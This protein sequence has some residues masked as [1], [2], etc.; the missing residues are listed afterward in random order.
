MVPIAPS[1]TR[2]RWARRG[3]RSAS[4]AS[5]VRP[6][7]DEE[8]GADWSTSTGRSGDQK[9]PEAKT[10]QGMRFSGCL[11]WP[12]A[13][14]IATNELFDPGKVTGGSRRGKPR[15]IRAGDRPPRGRS[16]RSR[17][18]SPVPRR[19]AR[20][21]WPSGAPAGARTGTG[22]CLVR[23]AVHRW[24]REPQLERVV[25]GA[26]DLGPRGAGL[27]VTS[28]AHAGRRLLDRGPAANHACGA[29]WTA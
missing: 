29:R 4:R 14:Q 28:Q 27:H 7:A 5:R 23:R 21:G 15:Q 12:Q 26:D 9:T 6:V 13:A 3:S 8:G 20:A 22:E 24:C 10:P 1:S 17:S 19:L 18:P 25:V 2:M 16:L 11:T